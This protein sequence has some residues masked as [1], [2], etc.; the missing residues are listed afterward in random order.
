VLKPY[1]LNYR[2]LLALLAREE[3]NE[4][5]EL[6][7]DVEE[8]DE[9][10]LP[11]II[12]QLRWIRR[13]RLYHM[14]KFYNAEGLAKNMSKDIVEL[15]LT[16]CYNLDMGPIIPKI[17]SPQL[18]HLDLTEAV[19]LNDSQIFILAERAH[20]LVSLNLSWCNE[21]TNNSVRVIVEKCLKL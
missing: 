7:V 21:L 14:E 19:Y 17:A 6:E 9:E 12:D 13:L 5:V 20:N 3:V 8:C 10:L 15:T 1:Q 2:S 11:K 18:L 16:K 4:I